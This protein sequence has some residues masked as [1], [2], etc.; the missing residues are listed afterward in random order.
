MS[1]APAHEDQEHQEAGEQPLSL[2]VPSLSFQFTPK[3]RSSLDPRCLPESLR[4]W[5][6]DIPS[7]F[8][9]KVLSLSNSLESESS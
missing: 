3:K 4:P 7:N 8:L 5:L 1:P 9:S 6:L 2:G